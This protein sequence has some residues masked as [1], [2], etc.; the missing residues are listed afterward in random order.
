V[1]Y[2]TCLGDNR[3]GYRVPVG[4]IY[5]KNALGRPRYKCDYIKINIK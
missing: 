3:K 4:K 1:G 2:V 5:G